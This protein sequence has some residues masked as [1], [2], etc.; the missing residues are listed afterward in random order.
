MRSAP[1][2]AMDDILEP[3]QAWDAAEEAIDFWQEEKARMEG[4]RW[5][6]LAKSF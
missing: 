5:Q 2:N 1:V 3:R 6:R 4:L